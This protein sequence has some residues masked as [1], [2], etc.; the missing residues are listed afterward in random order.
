MPPPVTATSPGG[1]EIDLAAVAKAAC[2]AYDAEFPDD[3]ERYGPV[4]EAWCVHDNQHLLNWATLS[5]RG[6]IDFDRQLA[7]LARVLEARDF[8]LDRLARNLELVAGTVA[9]HHPGE[10]ELRAR[11]RAGAE[12]VRSRTSFLSENRA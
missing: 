9:E 2:R 1:C 3:R 10:P 4:G 6:E 7:W 12:L 8:P 11:L 5:L